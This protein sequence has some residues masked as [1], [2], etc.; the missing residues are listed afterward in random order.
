MRASSGIG[1]PSSIASNPAMISAMRALTPCPAPRNLATKSP[2]PSVSTTAG[3]DPPSLNGWT[4]LAA[5]KTG[6]WDIVRKIL[7][8][9]GCRQN[10]LGG[11][12]DQ[13]RGD[14]L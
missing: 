6:N 13:G 8:P 14:P 11:G 12:A 4:Y 7:P 1:S 3:N 5:V 10:Q 9:S 2:P